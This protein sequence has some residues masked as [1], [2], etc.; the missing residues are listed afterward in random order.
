MDEIQAMQSLATALENLGDDAR[1]R[2]LSWANAKFGG[3]KVLSDSAVHTPSPAAVQKPAA[4]SKKPSGKASK[5]AKSI[6]AMN[7]SLN[8]S[9]SGKISAIQFQSEKS[10]KSVIQKC[11]V[12][13]Y[14]L[15]DI[16]ELEQITV[17]DVF[18]FFKTANWKVPADLKNTLQQA[19]S[20]GWLDTAD[21]EDIKITSMG[22]NLIEH[23][24]PG[25]TA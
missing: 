16:A 3:G 12:A 21:G 11:V 7:K 8:L 10:P 25:K 18:T 23:D 24:L 1:V 5:K 13:A 17:S 9:P 19:G 4:P 22:E 2:V 20:K 14:Y 6:I 15:R